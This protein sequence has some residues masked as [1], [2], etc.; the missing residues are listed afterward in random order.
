MPSAT[1]DGLVA[2]FSNDPTLAARL[3]CARAGSPRLPAH[4]E[5]S[6]T[7]S[8]LGPPVPSDRRVDLALEFRH[9]KRRTAIVL[10]EVQLRP[11]PDKGWT[12]PNYYAAARDRWRCPVFLIVVTPTRRMAKW[13][14]RTITTAQMTFTPFVLGPDEVPLITNVKLPRKYPELGVLSAMIHG[15]GVAL[16]R[17]TLGKLQ[18][19]DRDTHRTYTSL[20]ESSFG[21]PETT[22]TSQE[23]LAKH[24]ISRDMQAF[25]DK[26]GEDKGLEVFG[27]FLVARLLV[28]EQLRERE[29]K[30]ETRVRQDA[31]LELLA[32]RSLRIPRVVR[33]EIRQCTSTSRLRTMHRRALRVTHAEDVLTRKRLPTAG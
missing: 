17:A 7:R 11:D 23:F 1:H 19:L 29:A 21:Q 20:L 5:V 27:E 16:V 28:Q 30:I 9:R 31:I 33:A 22:M 15:Q 3:L 10:L 24:G 8:D 2:L 14:R 12:W 18:R 4:D 13:C 6:V 25:I 26:Y 32:E